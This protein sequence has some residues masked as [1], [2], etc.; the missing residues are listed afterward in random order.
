MTVKLKVAQTA[1]S[2]LV[3]VYGTT[4]RY[5]GPDGGPAPLMAHMD[6]SGL[7]TLERAEVLKRFIAALEDA[8]SRLELPEV[9]SSM[10]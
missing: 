2:G 1:A 10:E 9:A 5:C 8:E 4:D 3:T 7:A 6:G